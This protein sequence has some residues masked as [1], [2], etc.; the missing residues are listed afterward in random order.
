MPNSNTR[1]NLAKQGLSTLEQIIIAAHL[2]VRRAESSALDSALRAGEALISVVE[3]KL[4]RH[5]ERERFYRQ[6]CGHERTGRLYVYLAKNRDVID[7]N[8]N[9]DSGLS[10]A[11]ALGLIRKAKGVGKS[12]GS[13]SS[14]ESE[15]SPSP[16]SLQGWTDAEIAKALLA[17]G[18]D[19]FNQV[20]PAPF[21]ARLGQRANA[22]IVRLAQAQPSKTKLKDFVPRLIA[23]TDTEVPPTQ[24]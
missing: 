5:R 17:L 21:R 24:H 15:N 22:Q 20:I 18:F 3:R 6:T 14:A 7:A 10:I 4:I 13:G 11:E 23:G 12:R 16:K 1:S 19:R 8:R 2:G 9:R